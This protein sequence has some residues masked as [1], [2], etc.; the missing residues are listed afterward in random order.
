LYVA[1]SGA[2]PSA[3]AKPRTAGLAV[4]EGAAG[5]AA[6]GVRFKLSARG[7]GVVPW[8]SR[9][10]P[11]RT[12][13]ADCEHGDLADHTDAFRAY[14]E[15]LDSGRTKAL[16]QSEPA[17]GAATRAA[18]HDAAAL[19]DTLVVQPLP[20]LPA[21][22][23]SYV[24]GVNRQM[25]RPV[26]ALPIDVRIV[27]GGL[28]YARF[29]LIVG[30]YQND[31]VFGGTKR[32]DE[33]LGGQLSRMVDLKL[34]TGA[35]RTSVYLRPPTDDA[36][37]PAYPGAIVVGL[38]TVGELSPGSLAA[39][40]TRAVLRHAFDHLHRDPWVNADGTVQLR[41][42][43]L[44]VGTH[45]QAVTSRD[46]LA[47]VLAG[48][49]RA[50]LHLLRGSAGRPMQV[51]ELEIIEIQE[52]S[53][54]DAAYELQRLLQR[55]EWRD[56]LVWH[57][58]TLE[59]RSG[60]ISGYRPAQN[61][62]VWQR[63]MVR[64]QPLGGLR[65]ELIAEHARVEATQVQSDVASLAGFIQQMSD[66][67]VQAGAADSGLAFGQ[68]L[69]QLLLPQGL[70]NRMLNLDNT[71]LVL[72]DDAAGYPWELMV[73]PED[74][75][76]LGDGP[77]P[78]ALQAGMV[79]QRVA[80]DFRLLPTLASEHDVLVVGAPA[81]DGWRDR[82]GQELRFS[83]L[84][85]ALAEADG[86]C[87]WLAADHRPW[88]V[89]ALRGEAAPFQRVRMALL[90][91]PYRMLH[92]CGHGVVDFW[93][94]DTGDADQPQALRKTGMLL[95]RQQVL[96]AAD[97][98]QM[99]SVPE[100]VFINC[101]Y[102][103]RDGDERKLAPAQRQY[104]LLA[105]SLALK[106]IQMGSRAVVAAGWQVDDAD[107][108]V[109]AKALYAALLQD[110]CRFGDA[111]LLARKAVQARGGGGNTWGAY[112]CYGDPA[113]RLTEVHSRTGYGQQFGSS[114]LAGAAGAMSP[115]ELADRVL[116]VVAVAGD[117]PRAALLI[118]LEDLVAT[119]RADQARSPW[120]ERSRVRA[121]LGQA[122]REL[123]DHDRAVQWLQ[124]GSRNAY[125]RVALREVELMVNSLSR[126]G[127]DESHGIAGR[128]LDKLDAIDEGGLL[129]TPEGQV[130]V[131]PR[132]VPSAAKSERDCL[133][134]S[135]NMRQACN[136]RRPAEQVSR[137][138]D[139]CNFFT[140]G[141]GGKVTA[142]DAADRRAYALASA[143]LCAGLA[144]LHGASL[145]D[146]NRKIDP[147]R[148]E[149]GNDT[150][151]EEH[152][153]LLL[154]EIDRLGLGTSF[155]HY[156]NSLELVSARALLR[157]AISLSLARLKR[158]NRLQRQWRDA[159]TSGLGQVQ[160]DI[161][162]GQRL[163]RHALVRWPSPVEADSI[164]ER[165]AA[166]AASCGQLLDAPEDAHP[167]LA[168]FRPQLKALRDLA[169]SAVDQLSSD[170]AGAR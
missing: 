27:H 67:G 85:G 84:R 35:E 136:A 107:G 74:D 119:L 92:L 146:L 137:Y 60:A 91:Q 5:P 149:H 32:V 58:G 153:A 3:L 59:S 73:P 141:Y 131:V 76:T 26:A 57:A 133:R 103:G 124:A 62:S 118:Q 145:D 102:S 142:G 89:T 30:H 128:I 125:S 71:V 39:S 43:S 16:P 2:T 114:R 86:V 104:P 79:R 167:E 68:V 15:L 156:T 129:Y 105:A 53:A 9:L 8:L 90:A 169:D 23:G 148:R 94:A 40:V 99:Y 112:Q 126:I 36:L 116:Q 34:F 4:G 38:G 151:W 144:L 130:Q 47:A 66:A 46:S 143:M 51:A 21:D 159:A 88:R 106:F 31:G 123:G 157:V 98:D 140:E 6:S 87:R 163:L 75:S 111:V 33:K 93:V 29:P 19:P 13:Y 161:R 50:N 96:T 18:A 160:E 152:C 61:D 7:D 122:Y 121:A 150:G 63:L 139:A 97:V 165:F 132:G 78:L 20:S 52:Q 95:N 80:Y 70:K 117:K 154:D 83:T 55:D 162:R 81:T 12:W 170:K 77:T 42:S 48:I 65:F 69:Y 135:D 24:L 1:G 155:W 14:F 25:P 110:N 127:T 108:L 10:K 56:R 138:V 28:D 147:L 49:W 120:L 45:V 54:L 166:M 164:Q 44:L 101:C 109:F 158:P 37:P 72:D 168:K 113:W 22:F 82:A 64:Q 134:G 41:L 100:F 11:E 115:N 17:T